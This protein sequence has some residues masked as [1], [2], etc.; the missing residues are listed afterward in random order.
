MKFPSI[1]CFRYSLADLAEVNVL[2][3]PNNMAEL[4]RK[5][6]IL[7]IDDEDFLCEDYLRYRGTSF[8]SP[9]GSSL[10]TNDNQPVPC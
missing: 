4:R 2:Q 10:S 6:D 8:A 7:I 5:I 9:Q 1:Y 3:Q